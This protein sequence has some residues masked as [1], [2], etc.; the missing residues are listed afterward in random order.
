M[1]FSS[2]MR[3]RVQLAKPGAGEDD[4]GNP[5]GAE[6]PAGPMLPAFVSVDGKAKVA[7]SDPRDTVVAD[8]RVFL[9]AAVDVTEGDVIVWNGGRLEVI[10]VVDAQGPGYTHHREALCRTVR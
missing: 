5:D 7:T 1:S 6:V 9:D 4:R 10:G 2:L 8:F 3:H